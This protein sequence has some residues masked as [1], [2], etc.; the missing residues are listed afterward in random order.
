MACVSLPLGEGR[1]AG[2]AD[3]LPH[4]RCRHGRLAV[5]RALST[6]FDMSH[7]L[8]GGISGRHGDRT[9]ERS[10]AL[11]GFDQPIGLVFVDPPH[12]KMHPDGIVYRAI[13]GSF[14]RISVRLN[15]NIHPLQRDVLLLG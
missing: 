8:H 14:R 4:E 12:L 15:A 10:A 5:G 9:V 11:P 7:I 3:P 13:S 1:G 2:S 6:R